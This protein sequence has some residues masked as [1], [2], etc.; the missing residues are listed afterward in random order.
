MH[1]LYIRNTVPLI[2][3]LFSLQGFRFS[4]WFWKNYI[5][6]LY[7]KTC[8]W[9]QCK[10][11]THRWFAWHSPR[12]KEKGK[13]LEQ[14]RFQKPRVVFAEC[15]AV[16]FHSILEFR[17]HSGWM[18]M[19]PGEYHLTLTRLCLHNSIPHLFLKFSPHNHSLS[20]WL[21]G[22]QCYQQKRKSWSKQKKNP[23]IDLRKYIW[24]TNKIVNFG[25]ESFFP[26]PISWINPPSQE[27]CLPPR[28]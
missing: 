23:Q 8:C 28:P 6:V 4:T 3:I 10:M 12:K 15:N 26:R 17:N 27:T 9:I 22:E 2:F 11:E 14:L 5:E 18:W 21:H 25:H 13:L 20:D 24:Q 19:N 1:K 16:Y 7:F